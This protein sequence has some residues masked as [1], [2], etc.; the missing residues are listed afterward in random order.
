MTARLAIFTICS[1][2]YL[3]FA[4]V[5][6]ESARACHPE[7]DLFL[8]LADQPAAKPE[9]AG[10]TTL[11]ARDLGIEGF[12]ALAFGYGI[13]ELN[14]ALKPF[15]FIHLF[16]A[17]GYDT[18]LYFD[19]DVQL[20]GRLDEELA[21]LAGGASLI[22]TP[23]VLSPLEAAEPPD[24]I[25]I[26]RTGVYNLGFLGAARGPETMGLLQWWA[27]RLRHHCLDAQA[28]GLFVDQ[29]FM[30]LAP[31]F[32]PNCRIARNPGLNVA[33]WNLAQRPLSETPAGV[34]VGG[35]QAGGV[36]AGGRELLFFHFSGFDPRRP[37]R[38]SIY[39][40][41]F[42]NNMPPPLRT[43]AGAYA[44]SLLSNGYATEQAPPYAY[45]RFASG[46]R[47]HGYVRRMFRDWT[48]QWPGDPFTTYEAYLHQPWPDAASLPG[49]VVTNFMAYLWDVVPGLK[50]TFDVQR[51]EDVR[52]FVAWYVLRAAKDL[53]LDDTLIAP[54]R[55]RLRQHGI[56]LDEA[57][58]PA[59]IVD[60]S[61]TDNNRLV[62]EGLQHLRHRIAPPGSRREDAMRA[63]F[64]VVLRRLASR[65]AAARA[66]EAAR[67]AD[68]EA[69]RAA[70]GDF[71][72]NTGL[73]K[74][75]ATPR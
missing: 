1:N 65:T 70:R 51:P 38:L 59:N 71:V 15:M 52:R 19:P 20:F 39:T 41:R 23:H 43:L 22:L 53:G 73:D 40:T 5:F 49:C 3:P 13:K 62:L 24:D 30:D 45:D 56:S 42:R 31:A 18:V 25:T 63:I 44:D 58:A 12:A 72:T 66:A 4:R 61:I 75:P 29:K 54:V 74:A 16:E 35:V 26:L 7:A 68:A 2:N 33:Y 37:A 67:R 64:K 48:P 27:R 57:A 14:T 11:A 36:Q 10:W 21:A 50:T 28:E 47:V 6:F 60:K 32:A 55:A 9:A 69:N 34:Q 8:C 17:R 46:A